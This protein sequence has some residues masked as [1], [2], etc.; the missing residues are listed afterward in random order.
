MN[1]ELEALDRLWSETFGNNETSS[2]SNR[3]DRDLIK[4]SLQDKD[5]RIKE[6]QEDK[7]ELNHSLETGNKFLSTYKNKLN[8]ISGV[9]KEIDEYYEMKKDILIVPFENPKMVTA[10]QQQRIMEEYNTLKEN[11]LHKIKSILEG[12]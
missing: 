11:S 7:K 5:E 9:F 3:S 10:F 1:K 8:A 6:L 4:Q 2:F 12:E